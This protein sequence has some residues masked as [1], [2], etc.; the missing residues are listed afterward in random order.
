MLHQVPGGCNAVRSSKHC[1]RFSY[2][3]ASS[4]SSPHA[5]VIPPDSWQGVPEGMSREVAL[6]SIKKKKKSSNFQNSLEKVSL[7][8]YFDSISSLCHPVVLY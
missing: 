2:L 3:M 6:A 1:S 5:A 8:F 7:S 4:S